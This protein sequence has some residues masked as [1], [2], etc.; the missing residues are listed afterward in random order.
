[1][2]KNNK[3]H[4]PLGIAIFVI[5]LIFA[6]SK[7]TEIKTPPNFLICIADDAG[8]NHSGAYG[9]S[10]VRTPS[11]DKIA[12]EGILFRNAY[13]PNAKCSPSRACLLTG[14][15]SWQLEEACNHVPFFPPKF[16]TYQEALNDHGYYVG[17]TGKGWAPGTALTQDGG[18]R[19]LLVSGYQSISTVPPTG[20]ISE[21]D[22]S[23]NFRDFIRQ[24]PQNHPFCFWYGA[25]EPHRPYKFNSG[26]TKAGKSIT[27]LNA[28]IDVYGFW[29][30]SDTVLIDLLDYALEIEYFDSH[31]GKMLK[32]LE[33]EGELENTV[34]IVTS[35]HGMPF[36]RVKGQAYGPSNHVPLIIMWQAGINKPGRVIEDFVSFIDIAPTL[37]EL[38][39]ITQEASGMQQITGQSLS[40]ILFSNEEGVIDAGRDHVLIGK[41]RHDVGRPHD[42]GYPIRGMV[43]NEFLYLRNFATDRWPSGNPETG[44]LNCDGSPT[45]SLIL[46]MHRSDPGGGSLY[47][48][49]CFGMRPPEE[50][51]NL[52][53][54]PSCIRNLADKSEYAVLM[55]SMNKQLSDELKSQG[56][57]RFL[58]FP[59]IFDQ[60]QFAEP[61]RRNY[62]E[63]FMKG[64]LDKVGWVNETDYE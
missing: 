32:F 35:D 2:R 53:D 12:R 14:R 37:L 1:M 47:W 11:I 45:K 58:G 9:C 28:D 59:D 31:I 7:R 43:N 25:K 55:E 24:R 34:V 8:W 21:N 4:V 22:Y 56:D 19:D 13:T 39:G 17:Y 33:E 26:I 64:E 61:K 36:P 41:E 30:R 54:D 42:Q 6:C 62:Y 16:K 5:C 40:D 50:L 52:M 44:Y 46:Q 20:F 60:Y 23:G 57:P 15:N 3:T 63:R 27:E 51:Y 49:L 48:D 18:E 10:W 38:G 29:P